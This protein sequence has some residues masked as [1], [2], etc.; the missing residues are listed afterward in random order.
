MTEINTMT[1]QTMVLDSVKD[2][3]D[4]ISPM[5]RAEK[6]IGMCSKCYSS[7]VSVVFDEDNFQT[8]CDKCRNS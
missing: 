5:N 1:N 7:G 3:E 4:T 6:I 2:G 8:M